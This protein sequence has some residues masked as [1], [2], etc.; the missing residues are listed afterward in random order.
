MPDQEHVFLKF[1]I[2]HHM[3]VMKRFDSSIDDG[4]SKNYDDWNITCKFSKAFRSKEEA[5]R[6]E[7]WWLNKKLPA[8][9][10]KVWVEDYLSISNSNL[11]RNNTGITEMRLVTVDEAKRIYW[12]LYKYFK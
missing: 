9:T 1:G 4:Y 2:T 6:V 10:H 5:E 3:D 8:K 12:T 11:Y 7:Q